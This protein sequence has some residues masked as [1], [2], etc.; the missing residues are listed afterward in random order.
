MAYTPEEWVLVKIS[1][2]QPHYR[3]FGS[4]RGGYLSGDSWRMNSGVTSVKEVD[5]YYE[6]YGKS[7]SCYRCHKKAY[8][9]RSPYNGS[10]LGNYKRKLE[11][12]FNLIEKMPDVMNIDWLI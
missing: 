3:V 6:F 4:W 8:G 12:N 2:P 7:G 10:V 11:E 1:G 9:I 5:D